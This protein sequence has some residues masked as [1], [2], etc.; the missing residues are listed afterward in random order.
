MLSIKNSLASVLLLASYAAA[1]SA[2]GQSAINLE[3]KY[4]SKEN[5]GASNAQGENIY[6][7]LGLCNDHCQGKFAYAVLQWQECWCSN[8]KPS[9][10]VDVEDCNQTC[11]GYPDQ[12]C[13][14]KG[15]GLYSYVPLDGAPISSSNGTS[16]ASSSSGSVSPA[17]N[18]TMPG[19][20]TV[21]SG[22]SSTSSNST[23]SA[24]GNGN[25][26]SGNGTSSDGSD[27]FNSASSS[28]SVSALGAAF[29]FAVS[30]AFAFAA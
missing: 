6:Q 23:S 20:S 13:G 19:S 4:C 16:S 10:T 24:G 21:G 2:P 25:G 1:Q 15:A 7:T 18:S 22:S 3:V 30:C 12:K 14:N 5:T 17:S 29:G 11:P 27:D 9:E 28:L 26:H 8:D